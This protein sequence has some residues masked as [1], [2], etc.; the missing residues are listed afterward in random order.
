MRN[1]KKYEMLRYYND[2]VFAGVHTELACRC[3]K[4]LLAL[5]FG[6]QKPC[7]V[8]AREK[9]EG[10]SS[11]VERGPPWRRQFDIT[12]LNRVY[13]NILR[14]SIPAS[15]FRASSTEV[16]LRVALPT[17]SC[18]LSGN[19]PANTHYHLSVLCRVIMN[20]QPY[21]RLRPS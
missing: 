12:R 10:Y 17:S 6:A 7:L 8:T 15:L 19:L 2:E 21:S 14:S 20:S 1:M 13:P 18:S 16:T 3:A 5:R 9:L 11:E 4:T